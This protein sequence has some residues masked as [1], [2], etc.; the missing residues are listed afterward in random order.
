MLGISKEKKRKKKKTTLKGMKEQEDHRIQ[1]PS[2]QYAT[3]TFPSSLL[4]FEED[5]CC[6]S[7][8]TFLFALGK[9]SKKNSSKSSGV[10]PLMVSCG[11]LALSCPLDFF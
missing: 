10:S 8:A 1:L 3:R 5:L 11:L 2:T 7:Q 9:E 6:L 4:E